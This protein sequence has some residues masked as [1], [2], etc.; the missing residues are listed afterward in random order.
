[1]KEVLSLY[2]QNGRRL[3]AAKAASNMSTNYLLEDKEVTSAML[4]GEILDGIRK[5]PYGE[6]T[7]PRDGIELGVFVIRRSH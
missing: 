6:E 7:E 3:P 1:M 4:L 5:R 2:W